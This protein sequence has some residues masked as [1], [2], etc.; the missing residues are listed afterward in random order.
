M[1]LQEAAAAAGPL[2][3]ILDFGLD[4]LS[5]NQQLTFKL[6]QR[7]VFAQ[8]GYVFWVNAGNAMNV[9]G[10]LHY[11]TDRV[12]EEDQTIGVNTMIFSSESEITQFNELKPNFMWIASWTP[13]SGGGPLLIA[14]SK[15][16]RFY[17]PAKVW[18]YVGYAV[19]PALSELLVN[20]ENE[21][22]VGPIVSNSL[23][24]WLSQT[25]VGAETI[26]V[27]P[28]FLVPDNAVPPYIT[29]HVEP[30]GTE[31]VQGF[32][33]YT[34]P[35]NPV[36]GLNSLVSN[37]LMSDKVR[38]TLYGLTNQMAI[39]YFASLIDYS[40]NSD[41]FGFSN[42][43][44]IR[45]EKRPQVEIAAIAMKKTIEVEATYYMSTADAISRKLILSAGLTFI[46]S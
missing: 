42:S 7:Y 11:S 31:A 30:A 10:S 40:R 23:P 32:P 26:P 46:P 28:S 37:Q 12:Q 43:P 20:S 22:P 19:Y 33:A 17:E 29:A 45:D 13:P 34:W 8:D 27:Y 24:I 35:T 2:Q 25:T 3:T 39:Q 16:G 44:A 14:F 9:T 6:Y 38:L 18:H 41:A 5:K 21:L 1:N 15:R 36:T 4:A